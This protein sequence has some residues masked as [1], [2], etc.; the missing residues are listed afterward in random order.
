MFMLDIYSFL[1]LTILEMCFIWKLVNLTH[2]ASPCCASAA[3]QSG[4]F[5]P[6]FSLHIDESVISGGKLLCMICCGLVVFDYGEFILVHVPL[7]NQARITGMNPF[8]CFFHQACLERHTYVP[9]NV[10]SIIIK[11]W[12]ACKYISMW[13]FWM[14]DFKITCISSYR[15]SPKPKHGA[16]TKLYPSSKKIWQFPGTVNWKFPLFLYSHWFID[17]FFPHPSLPDLP[18]SHVIEHACPWGLSGLGQK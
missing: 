9:D 5:L 10:G 12:Q 3:R 8:L 7:C 14:C 15:V 17:C 1:L 11:R 6:S 4:P 13:I 18:T 16:L 2:T